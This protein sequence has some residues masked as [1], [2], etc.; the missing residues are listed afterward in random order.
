MFASSLHRESTDSLMITKSQPETAQEPV[1][2]PSDALL[3]T[4]DHMRSKFRSKPTSVG[5]PVR[6]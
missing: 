6:R 2:S 5:G 4:K 3:D 1:G